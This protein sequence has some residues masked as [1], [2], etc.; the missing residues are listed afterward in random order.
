MS[1]IINKREPMVKMSVLVLLVIC[2]LAGSS[3]SQQNMK[4][5]TI[6]PI[7]PPPQ[8]NPYELDAPEGLLSYG[9]IAYMRAD[10]AVIDDFDYKFSSTVVFLSSDKIPVSS[11]KFRSGMKVG[12][13]MNERREIIAMWVDNGYRPV[14]PG[15]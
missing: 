5:I 3:W 9:K 8:F 14:S 10:G 12:F 13:R 15:D 4:T 1:W 2:C 11:R 7:E 6:K